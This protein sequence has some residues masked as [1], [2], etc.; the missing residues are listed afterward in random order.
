MRILTWDKMKKELEANAAFNVALFRAIDP[1]IITHRP[2]DPE[3]T[4]LMKELG[5]DMPAREVSKKVNPRYRKSSTRKLLRQNGGIE[6]VP[7]EEI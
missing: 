2:R 4:R 6:K 1:R 3:K 5:M 7:P